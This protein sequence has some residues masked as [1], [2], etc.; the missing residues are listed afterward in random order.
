[1]DGSPAGRRKGPAHA[2]RRGLSKASEERLAEL[3]RH[4]PPPSDDEVKVMVA[5]RR[6]RI[7]RRLA[8][9]GIVAL[10]VVLG[11]AAVAQW[12][13]P[14]PPPAMSA[15]ASAHLPGT[16]PTLPWPSAGQAALSVEGVGSLGQVHGAQPVPIAGLADVLSAYVILRDHP[17]PAGGDGPALT[18]NADT[19]GAYQSGMA[20][21]YSEVPVTLGE[22]LSERQ[23]LEGLL[24][25]S[26]TDMATLL[27]DWDAA[28]VDAFVAKLNLAA[29]KLG[30]G[31]THITDPSGADPA[32]TS[33]AEDLVRLGEAAM[34]V[35]ALRQIASLGQTALPGSTVVYNLNYELGR[36]GIV[37]LKTGSDSA[38]HGCYL[39]A[40]QQSV[41]GTPV[42]VIGAVLGQTGLN[43]PNTAAVGAGDALVKAA[44][45][46]LH[47]FA[48]FGAGQTVGTLVTAWGA[49]APVTVSGPVSVLGWS[50]LDVPLSAH[51]DPLSTP[52]AAGSHIGVLRAGARGAQAPVELRTAGALTGPTTWWRLTR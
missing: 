21:Q 29:T 52:V 38:A 4:L 49:S 30:M 42:T 8:V 48:L 22:H 24:V 47:P 2:Q 39:V 31:S 23:A 32:T 33:T 16:P 26:G 44:F 51:V 9:G 25:D 11:A 34:T 35:P 20:R 28:S 6:A 5:D 3:G 14:V 12:V 13:R 18:V 46:S 50:G 19:V 7:V 40:A 36:D 43:G 15:L 41:A 1:M 37:G 27:A 45:S 17:L 10:V